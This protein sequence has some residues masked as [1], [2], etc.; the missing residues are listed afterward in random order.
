MIWN[1]YHK[2]ILHQ[3]P[4]SYSFLV[5][6]K[7][8][9]ILSENWS[10][11]HD[12]KT[13]INQVCIYQYSSNTWIKSNNSSTDEVMLLWYAWK[14]LFLV[15]NMSWKCGSPSDREDFFFG[16]MRTSQWIVVIHHSRFA[17]ALIINTLTD[18]E[19]DSHLRST[20]FDNGIL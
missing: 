17:C 1:F 13:C 3:S 19:K 5:L 14:I 10:Q 16:Q 4:R 2:F 11:I 6:Y 15:V 7:N 12:F 9:N 20:C 8:Q 18:R